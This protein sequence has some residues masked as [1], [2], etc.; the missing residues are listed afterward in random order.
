MLS[1]ALGRPLYINIINMYFLLWVALDEKCGARP[2]APKQSLFLHTFL[3]RLAFVAAR[4]S[5]GDSIGCDLGATKPTILV[6]VANIGDIHAF[7]KKRG[8]KGR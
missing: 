2:N 8:E 4:F 3:F 6:C 7:A 1:P 5:C